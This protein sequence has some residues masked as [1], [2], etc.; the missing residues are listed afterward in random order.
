M[1][2]KLSSEAL[3]MLYQY[4][5]PGNVRELANLIERVLIL[6]NG[7]VIQVKDLPKKVIED[8][9]YSVCLP[10]SAESE[11]MRL[12]LKDAI[13]KF[14]AKIIKDS[15]LKAGT[16]E[17]AAEMLGINQSTIARKAK[18]YGITR[19]IFYQHNNSEQVDG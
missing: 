1:D 9:N 2:K 14:E 8:T 4:P 12:S 18:K 10:L 6:A 13:E 7:P 17:G 11:E 19:S 3:D 16:Q 5:F 15:L